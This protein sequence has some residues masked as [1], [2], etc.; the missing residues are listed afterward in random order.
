MPLKSSKYKR[1]LSKLFRENR[2]GEI[3]GEDAIN[4]AI[5]SLSADADFDSETIPLHLRAAWGQKQSKAK[6]S[7]IYY[8][9][10]DAQGRM[11]EIS[12]NGWRIINGS[13]PE[14]PILFRRYNQT[15]Q[16]TPD[17]NYTKDFWI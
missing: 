2:N 6:E 11:V 12:L 8:D 5:S 3:I 16:V 13:D 10:T 7:C 1:Y 4:N 14:V 15:S 17:R 9:M